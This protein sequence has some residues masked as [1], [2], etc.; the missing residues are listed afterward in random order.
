M[1]FD[2]GNLGELLNNSEDSDIDSADFGI[3]EVDPS[4]E[5]L[6]YNVYESE[7]AGVPQANAIGKNLFTEIAPCT[8]NFMVANKLISA[9]QEDQS[10]DETLDYVFTYKLKPTKVTLRLVRHNNRQWMCVTQ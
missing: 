10:L 9:A 5:I 1:Q 8:N 3:V 6:T 4:G 2:S 7:L